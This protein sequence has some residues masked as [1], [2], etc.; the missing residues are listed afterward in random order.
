MSII[1]TT[2]EPGM[3]LG[4]II[5]LL[6]YWLLCHASEPS[7]IQAIANLIGRL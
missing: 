5:S 3:V 2:S 1:K 6:I 7:I 4:I